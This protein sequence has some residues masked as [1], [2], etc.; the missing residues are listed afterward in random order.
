MVQTLVSVYLGSPCLGHTIKINYKISDCLSRDVLK[1][2]FLEK[3]LELVS[4]THFAY[5]FWRKIFLISHSFN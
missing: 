4:P 1:P 3:S 5:D 2:D